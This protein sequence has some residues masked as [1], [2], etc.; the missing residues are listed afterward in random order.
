MFLLEPI[1]GNNR[2]TNWGANMSGYRLKIA[3]PSLRASATNISSLWE[4]SIRYGIRLRVEMVFFSKKRNFWTEPIFIFAS[5]GR[6]VGKCSCWLKTDNISLTIL[7]ITDLQ[8]YFPPYCGSTVV[9]KDFFQV[10]LNA[11]FARVFYITQKSECTL[12][13][14]VKICM[15]RM[16]TW[17]NLHVHVPSII[18]Q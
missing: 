7:I 6:Y 10:R 16:L 11:H 13:S 2:P 12:E 17:Q 14:F 1:S 5:M 8:T 18:V 4:E 9:H 15:K 3:P